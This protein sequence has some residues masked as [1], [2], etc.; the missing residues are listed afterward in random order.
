ME[1]KSPCCGSCE[2]G[3]A[4]LDRREFLTY[5]IVGL[6]GIIGAAVF[7]PA[8]GY[9]LA[10]LWKATPED[11][12]LLGPVDTLPIGKPTQIEFLQR[13]KDGWMTVGAKKTTWIVTQDGKEFTAFDPLCTHLGCPYSWDESRGQFLC[14]C[15]TGI[16]DLNGQVLSGPPPRP[17]DRFPTK[18][19]N[20]KLWVLPVSPKKEA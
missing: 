11:W 15:H 20:G 18:V 1:K 14:P 5:S 2:K 4:K 6:S 10:P 16:F 17:L 3:V 7:A 8:I 19:E 12:I 9:F 13:R